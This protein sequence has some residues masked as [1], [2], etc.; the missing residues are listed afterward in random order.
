MSP[1]NPAILAVL[2]ALFLAF[3][4]VGLVRRRSQ[5]RR[6][7]FNHEILAGLKDKASLWWQWTATIDHLSRVDPGY[8]LENILQLKEAALQA[9]D[10][11]LEQAHRRGF[12]K[13]LEGKNI[14]PDFLTSEETAA[15]TEAARNA[16]RRK[17]AD[18]MPVTSA[19][20]ANRQGG[21]AMPRSSAPDDA[22]RIEE[23]RQKQDQFLDAYINW[24]ATHRIAERTKLLEL[25][26]Q[27][28]EL[29]PSFQFDINNKD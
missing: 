9:F 13:L 20:A 26:R 27:L 23:I 2:V 22:K 29:D 10:S 12:N 14:P 5:N 19:Q 16:V 4:A 3:L 8:P 18:R 11:T 6:K 24:K 25:A 1:E 15:I 28:Q 7:R 21:Q 17:M